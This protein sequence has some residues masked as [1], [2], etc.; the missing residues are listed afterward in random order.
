[1]QGLTL[2]DLISGKP[3]GPEASAN[4]PDLRF[5]EA[6][7]LSPG[8]DGPEAAVSRFNHILEE[9]TQWQSAVSQLPS[10][11]AAIARSDK[12]LVAAPRGNGFTSAVAHAAPGDTIE[13]DNGSLPEP[14]V[15][16][17]NALDDDALWE[18]A[19]GRDDP[20]LTAMDGVGS[21]SGD[22][23][24]A[25]GEAAA[26]GLLHIDT[27]AMTYDQT[28][29]LHT[30]GPA[31]VPPHGQA[32][33]ASPVTQDAGGADHAETEGPKVSEISNPIRGKQTGPGP[34]FARPFDDATTPGKAGSRRQTAPSPD[35]KASPPSDGAI[36]WPAAVSAGP[37]NDSATTKTD[38]PT[39]PPAIQID[40]AVAH[41]MTPS[42]HIAPNQ[43][44]FAGTEPD[45]GVTAPPVARLM[46]AQLTATEA[47]LQKPPSPQNSPTESVALAETT[48]AEAAKAPP[49][50]TAVPLPSVSAQRVPGIRASAS[51]PASDHIEDA[52]GRTPGRVTNPATPLHNTPSPPILSQADG[53]PKAQ[54]L[55]A[56]A[57]D[58]PKPGRSSRDENRADAADLRR[59]PPPSGTPAAPLPITSSQVS[60]AIP[61]LSGSTTQPVAVRFAEALARSQKSGEGQLGQEN[62]I[63]RAEAGS[64]HHEVRLQSTE[65]RAQPSLPQTPAGLRD[66]PLRIVR[67]L[68]DGDARLT[69]TLRPQELGRLHM[70]LLFVDGQ[71]TVDISADRPETLH[72]LQREADGL[73]RSLRQAGLD[74]RNGGL[75]FGPHGDS[76]RQRGGS[77]SVW[78]GMVR[79]G[80]PGSDGD[81]AISPPLQR[82]AATG[83]ATARTID[84]AL[85]IRL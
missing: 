78:R 28:E 56:S 43:S 62:P 29:A 6:S 51:W 57:A 11:G 67:A 46:T 40:S 60:P 4:R 71:L 17:Y 30:A 8:T 53:G 65:T 33:A 10:K 18:I 80:E 9:S 79:P 5:G 3:P 41:A 68:N 73:E 81:H 70:R 16:P 15:E 44:P 76:G 49:D 2:S 32:Q 24:E 1:M 45:T 75:H 12:G 63:G 27:A 52:P 83:Q 35:A 38:P 69:L 72:L 82:P 26:G 84:G 13:T 66:I 20:V 34:L 47:V 42:D 58:Q 31:P 39:T 36:H 74:L 61:P 55:A 48:N 54:R 19:F 37:P 23:T 21:Q 64:A 59:S 50:T 25:A 85:D 77:E 14:A 7:A 22:E